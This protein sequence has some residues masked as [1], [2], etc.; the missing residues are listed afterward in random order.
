MVAFVAAI[1]CVSR[2]PNVQGSIAPVGSHLLGMITNMELW[3]IVYATTAV[4]QHIIYLA[5]LYAVVNVIVFYRR[6]CVWRMFGTRQTALLRRTVRLAVQ[7]RS[8]H[9]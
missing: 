4:W 2:H 9:A 6:G 3:P 7:P 1:C 5:G 8:G